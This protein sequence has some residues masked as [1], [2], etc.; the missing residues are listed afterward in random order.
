MSNYSDL[1]ATELLQICKDEDLTWID[2]RFTDPRGKWQHL[3]MDSSFMDEDTLEE[4]LM[5]DG[6]S[7]A[8]WKAIN[9]SDMILKPDLSYVTTD[10]FTAQGTAVVY[11]DILEPSTG[12]PY[13]RDPR[14]TAK[15]AEEYLKF[16][17]I[18]DTVYIGPEPEFFVFDDVRFKVDYSGA[19]YQLDDI[20]G[21][22]NS[23]KIYPEGNMGHRPRVKGG[24]FP[25][26]PVDSAF[27]LRGE[28]V[29]ILREMGVSMDKHHHEVGA[30]QHE[31]GITFG[32]LTEM[33]DKIQLYKYVVHQVAHSYGKTAT[34][35]PK[36]VKDDNGSGMHVHQSIWK[37]GKPLFAGSGYADL[38]DTALYYIGGIIKHAKAINAFTNPSTNSY[39]R[40]TPGF[41]APVLLAYSAR[42]RSAS[43][44]IPYVSSPKGKRVE[45][46]FPDATA[47]PYLAFSAMLMAGLDGIE[48][49]IHPGDAMDKDLYALPPEELTGVPTVARSLR[50]ALEALQSDS[51]FLKKGDVFSQ[52]Q[53]DAYVHLKFEE[54]TRFE[55][56]PH[57]IEFDMYYSS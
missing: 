22:Y 36:P 18:G 2:L 15:R 56:S 1:S 25:V 31:L 17:G 40:L 50:E 30:S 27:D 52:D 24:Y 12:Q 57:P 26:A 6:S 13:G 14:S 39:K 33:A 55:L 10:P 43:C 38:S 49:R 41:E 9:E 51:D 48:N 7:I 46:R 11:C 16:T 23:D 4:G 21:P 47:N 29:T 34:F 44:R 8:G 53:I 28:M 32:K 35:M 19:M 20:E 54:V 45:V 37:D 42:N 3:T 5:F